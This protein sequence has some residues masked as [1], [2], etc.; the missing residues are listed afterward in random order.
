[1]TVD[2]GRS[3]PGSLHLI[4]DGLGQGFLKIFG[5]EDLAVGDARFD[6][7]Y[8]VRARPASLAS[9]VFALQRRDRVISAVRRIGRVQR[10]SIDL[11]RNTLTIQA[12][13]LIADLSGLNALIETTDEFLDF[14]FAPAEIPSPLPAGVEI[15][16]LGIAAGGECPVCGTSM[17]QT[18]VRC[19][20]C[21]TPHHVECWDYMGRCSTFACGGKRSVKGP[22]SGHERGAAAS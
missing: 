8:V 21:R 7:D 14:L 11:D 19:E 1:M 16:D 6:E 12:R 15:G 9:R 17:N 18:T 10:P 4:P 5:A 20:L 2:L 3:S 13:G 22:L